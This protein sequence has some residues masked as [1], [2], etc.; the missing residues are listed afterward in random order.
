MTTRID[1]GRRHHESG[2]HHDEHRGESGQPWMT[3]VRADVLDEGVTDGVLRHL[4]GL[5][6]R[7]RVGMPGVVVVAHRPLLADRP[8]SPELAIVL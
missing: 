4:L 7:S 5:G 1:R 3:G 8:V 6:G 2:R